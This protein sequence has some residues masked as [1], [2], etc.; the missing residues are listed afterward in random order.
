MKK[1]MMVLLAFGCGASL[2]QAPL[3]PDGEAGDHY[4][5]PYSVNIT[6]DGK[7]ED[8]AGVPKVKVNK[9]PYTVGE[10][11]S[12]AV[13][14]DD[15]NLYYM[16]D[17][18][19]SKR[20]AGTHNTDYWNEDT[21]EFYLNITDDIDA[22]TY[23]KGIIQFWI[24][25][26]NSDKTDGGCVNAGGNNTV[27]DSVKCRLIEKA[28]KSGFVAEVSVP[29]EIAGQG[30]SLKPEHG[31]IIGFQSQYNSASVT[32]RDTKLIWSSNDRTDASWRNPSKFGRLVFFK[33]GEKETPKVEPRE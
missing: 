9:G 11:Y 3:A 18:M 19:D 30:W 28:D 6:V 17:V 27:K 31:K 14:A 21:V 26:L 23:D 20:V 29:L 12:F 10:S 5:A 8:W 15:K 25:R 7:L 32:D 22:A 33:V 24:P 13:A 1:T 16:A 2:A 4:F